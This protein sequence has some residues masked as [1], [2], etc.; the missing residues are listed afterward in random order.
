MKK[1]YYLKDIS[2]PTKEDYEIIVW[3]W[4]WTS[5]GKDEERYSTAFMDLIC[6]NLNLN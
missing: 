2:V 4:K 5:F 6:S 3:I 1:V